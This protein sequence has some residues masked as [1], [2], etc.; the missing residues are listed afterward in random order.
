MSLGCFCCPK[1]LH[2]DQLVQS[3]VWPSKWDGLRLLTWGTLVLSSLAPGLLPSTRARSLFP[4]PRPL[5]PH[6]HQAKEMLPL[7]HRSCL[8]S[9]LPVGPTALIHSLSTAHPGD[10]TSLPAPPLPSRF[11]STWYPV[12]SKPMGLSKSLSGWCDLAPG[13]G[14]VMFVPS[15]SHTAVFQHQR[16]LGANLASTLP[17]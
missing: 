2:R 16:G 17:N 14:L 15:N 10:D 8:S 9:S 4:I 11:I 13:S 7:K 5:H 3:L 6:S 12:S 1:R